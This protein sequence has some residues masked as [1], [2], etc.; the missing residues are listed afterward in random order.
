MMIY[1]ELYKFAKNKK[2]IILKVNGPLMN[3]FNICYIF[4]T[5]SKEEMIKL[6][7]RVKKECF[8]ILSCRDFGILCLFNIIGTLFVA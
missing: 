5:F 1:L 6:Q 4:L 3:R 8:S 2:F 7:S